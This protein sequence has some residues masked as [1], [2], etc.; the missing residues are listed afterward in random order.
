MKLIKIKIKTEF[1][2]II[3]E[4]GGTSFISYTKTF[5]P[6]TVIRGMF[7]SRYINKNKLNSLIAHNDENFRS[8]FLNGNVS[9]GNAYIASVSDNSSFKENWPLPLSLHHDKNDENNIIDLLLESREAR[10]ISQSKAFLGYGRIEN[11]KLYT[12]DIKKYMFFHHKRDRQ[13]G[14]PE[15]GMLFNYE[16]L[17]PGQYFIGDI[18]ILNNENK[19]SDIFYNLFCK[20]NIFYIG[21]SKNSQYGKIHCELE[22]NHN[23]EYP[24][25]INNQITITFTSDAILV[26]REGKYCTDKSAI[27]KYFNDVL[28]ISIKIEKAFSRIKEIENFV[29]A[30]KLRRPTDIALR[31]GSCFSI[32]LNPDS[33][34]SNKLK[35]L[36]FFGI[37]ERREEGFG[38]F[39]LNWQSASLEKHNDN[40]ETAAV[41]VQE[42]QYQYLEDLPKFPMIITILINHLIKEATNLAHEDAQNFDETSLKK[43]SNSCL[44]RL[45]KAC[46]QFGTI[47]G[48]KEFLSKSRQNYINSLENI[49]F[50]KGTVGNLKIF[51]ERL[52]TTDMINRLNSQLRNI[53]DNLSYSKEDFSKRVEQIYL[54][55]LV[56]SL[57]QRQ[58]SIKQ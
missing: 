3:S 32:T 10:N 8:F 19:I 5:I 39:V 12:Q 20:E 51:L 54:K 24:N 4:S 31:A 6:G 45:E 36:S 35:E 7:A 13:K 38:R 42:N 23:W 16:C 53:L 26:D 15:E 55:T 44:A 29:S 30:W 58:K 22:N 37:G 34:K 48:L 33:D 11:K 43:A 56:N 25:N 50:S 14:S 49:K 41:P 9:F 2:V 57:R 17:A 1:P 47:E 18:R 28:K 21:R 46:I 27:E 52:E 40:Q